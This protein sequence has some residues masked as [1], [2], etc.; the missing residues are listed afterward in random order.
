MAQTPE[1]KV[2]KKITDLLKK[3]GVYYFFP[4]A[5]GY[6]SAGIPDIICCV[7]GYFL[8]IE[9]KAPGKR[10]NTTALQDSQLQAI[11]EAGG[12]AV[13]ST[14]EELPVI[15]FLVKSLQSR[16]PYGAPKI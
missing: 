16:P 11:H 2:K 8:A 9:V 7:N 4:V 5:S 10:Q 15:E 1:G 13:V 12:L 6:S 3:R 14:D